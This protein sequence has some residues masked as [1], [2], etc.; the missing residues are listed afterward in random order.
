MTDRPVKRQAPAME[1]TES[2]EGRAK[3]LGIGPNRQAAIGA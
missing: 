3:M 1:S 2:R